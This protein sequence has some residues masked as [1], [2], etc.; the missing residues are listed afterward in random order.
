MDAD[1]KGYFD[2][3]DHELLIKF[4]RE[5]ITDGWVLGIIKS[6]LTAGVMTDGIKEPTAEGA[7]QGGV[8]SPL[9]ANIYLHQMDKILVK[10]GY[11]I[12]RFA[13]DFVVMTK[14]KGKAKRALEVI[15][16]I[17]KDEL[18]LKL[19]PKKTKITNFGE[20]FIFLG[21]EFIAWRYKRPKK[22]ALDKFKDKIRKTTKRQQPW[23]VEK[24]IKW[25]NEKIRG[26]GNYYGH[27][28]VKKLFQRLDKWI[29][30]RVRSYMEKK[31]AVK[32]QNKRIPTSVLQKKGLVSLLTT[33]S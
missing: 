18:K 7:P 15:E 22:S 29:R 32:N 12:V 14:S 4:I 23:D 5:E 30:M 31:K 1:I 17:V 26:W 8:I 9:L 2:N 28:N 19:H 27:G 21:F 11:K 10:R 24:I 3:I 16:E 6:W 13:D 20:G 33:L 25:L